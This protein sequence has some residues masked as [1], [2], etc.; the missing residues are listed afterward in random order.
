MVRDVRA[1]LKLL[2]D[3]KD[4]AVIEAEVDPHLELPEIHRRVIAANGPALMFLRPKGS[5]VPVVTNLFGTKERV[6]LAFGSE[7]RRF[8]EQAV[9][10]LHSFPPTP[11]KL[12][13]KRSFL[14]SATRIGTQRVRHAPV[15]EVTEAPALDR[16]G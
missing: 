3:R 14:R 9:E 8:V 16:I 2:H 4:L 6:D 13:Q 15:T 1:L 12:W 7:P 5:D 10:M 11:R